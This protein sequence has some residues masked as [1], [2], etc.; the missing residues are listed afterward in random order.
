MKFAVFAFA[1]ASMV[2]ASPVAASDQTGHILQVAADNYGGGY[3]FYAGARTGKPACA[4]SDDY[5][6]IVG[7]STDN[8]KAML[9]LILTA[10]ATGKTV[11]IH[12]N[13][14]CDVGSPTRESVGY[15]VL[16]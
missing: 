7:P 11:I 5:W 13:G 10:Y 6:I 14:S 9:S 16:Q 3:A 12:G 15:I 8:A 1:L 2:F 4:A